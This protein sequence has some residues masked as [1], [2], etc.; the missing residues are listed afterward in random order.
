[1]CYPFGPVKLS[2]IVRRISLLEAVRAYDIGLLSGAGKPRAGRAVKADLCGSI[3][4]RR[5]HCAPRFKHMLGLLVP[6]QEK[7]AAASAF[8]PMAA[9]TEHC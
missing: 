6:H 7:G 5:P 4:E 9:A 2:I 8:L 3:R 1:M